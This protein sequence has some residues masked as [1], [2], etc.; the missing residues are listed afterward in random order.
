MSDSSTIVK[1]WFFIFDVPDL[2]NYGACLIPLSTSFFPSLQLRAFSPTPSP[3]FNRHVEVRALAP[4]FT[5]FPKAQPPAL[6]CVSFVAS[7]QF[8]VFLL[9][10]N[11]LVILF[12]LLFCIE[13]ERFVRLVM[14]FG[15]SLHVF[16]IKFFL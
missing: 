14:S 4:S 1:F 3:F 5:R 15:A 10:L 12:C 16:S 6:L 9:L 7:A 11:F 13:Q 2:C 8:V